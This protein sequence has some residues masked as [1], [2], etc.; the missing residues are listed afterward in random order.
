MKLWST[1]L[2][3]PDEKSNILAQHKEI[4]NGYQLI[5]PTQNNMQPLYTQDFAKDK[6]GFVVN[7][8]GVIKPYTNYRINENKSKQGE[9]CVSCGG[10][11]Y[12]NECMECGLIHERTM[13]FENLDEDIYD[14]ED[15]DPDEEFDYVEGKSNKLNT[16]KSKE[17]MEGG[18]VY[19]VNEFEEF[20]EQ[21]VSG[22]QGIYG[23]MK[24][25]YNFKSDGPGKAG[26]YQR[27][28]V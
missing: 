23:S 9:N 21:D 17:R 22:S 24:R 2:I 8:K 15:I 18:D 25:P 20:D 5:Q 28:S 7:N 11:L 6:E 4:Y 12:E 10:Y 13:F 19:P 16:F 26:P 27:F 3:S 1:N 14:I